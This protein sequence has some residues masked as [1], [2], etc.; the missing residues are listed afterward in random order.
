MQGLP[1]DAQLPRDALQDAEERAP[2][3]GGRVVDAAAE[4]RVDDTADGPVDVAAEGRVDD[5]LYLRKIEF[6]FKC[7]TYFTNSNNAL[8]LL[9]KLS[10]CC[11]R[12]P[13]G[14]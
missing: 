9:G 13:P 10:G 3:A 11:R 14:P 1:P 5:T 4:G 6:V 12:R 8:T 7:D 2:V